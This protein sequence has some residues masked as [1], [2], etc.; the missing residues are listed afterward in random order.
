MKEKRRLAKTLL[1][2]GFIFVFFISFTPVSLWLIY[3]LESQH[4]PLTQEQLARCNSCR[5][6]VLAG[7]H[8]GTDYLPP[9]AQ[10]S[11]ASL[12]RIVEGARIYKLGNERQLITSGGS[13]RPYNQANATARV[14]VNLGVLP[15]HI[16]QAPGSMN[17]Y[18][19]LTNYKARFGSQT[20]FILVTSAYHM[21]RAL[22]ICEA[23][24]LKPIPAPTEYF[25]KTPSK[26]WTAFWPTPEKTT[27]CSIL[28]HEFGANIKLNFK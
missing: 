25:I 7:G 11:P 23:L 18:E 20:Q 14:A 13:I 16:I 15:D 28:A 5:I 4:R 9:S 1:A 3:K 6:L 22:R 2:S 24:N 12:A 26:I 19:E 10:L 8:T 21:P 17:T 27:V